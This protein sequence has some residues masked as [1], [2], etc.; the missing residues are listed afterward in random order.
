VAVASTA[1]E[2]KTLHCKVLLMG[3]CKS[4]MPLHRARGEGGV[5]PSPVRPL[6]LVVVGCLLTGCDVQENRASEKKM[7]P[8]GDP[9]RGRAIVASGQYGCTACH[10]IPGIRSPQ[11]IVGPP[12]EGLAGRAF[13]AGQLPN[14]PDTLVAFLQNPAALIPQTGMPDVRLGLDEARHVAAFLYTLEP[15]SER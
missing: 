14:R 11:G 10:T 2:S 3:H 9:A 8:E 6:A 5:A 12:L 4:H 7:V 13:I 1:G 15:S